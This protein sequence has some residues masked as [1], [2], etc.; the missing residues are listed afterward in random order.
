MHGAVGQGCSAHVCEKKG[1][2]KNDKKKKWKKKKERKE[3]RKAMCVNGSAC[4]CVDESGFVD[5]SRACIG[6]LP[7]VLDACLC[8]NGSMRAVYVVCSACVCEQ[9]A[10]VCECA[11]LFVG[12]CICMCVCMGM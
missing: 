6:G 5:V 11:Y 4:A 1:G 12:V 10:C 3:K 2:K 7:C 9:E 8:V